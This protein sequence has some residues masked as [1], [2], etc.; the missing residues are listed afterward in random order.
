MPDVF[1][2]AARHRREVLERDTAAIK[3]LVLAYGQVY[4]RI[5]I[6]LDSLLVQMVAAKESG[7]E[8]SAAWLFQE[9]RLLLLERLVEQQI[10]DF[11]RISGAAIED[12]QRYLAILGEQHTRELIMLGLSP[13]PAG[14]TVAFSYLPREALDSL[15]GFLS[16]GSPLSDLLSELGTDASKSV[17]TALIQ[18]VGTGMGPRETAREIRTALGGNLTRALTISRQETLRAYREAS[19]QSAQRNSDVMRGWI[20]QSALGRRVCPLCIAKH[21][22]FHK[23]DERLNSHIACRCTQVWITKS[24]AELGFPGVEDTSVQR[25]DITPGADWFDGLKPSTQR[26]ILGNAKYAAWQSGAITLDDLVAEMHSRQWG[27]G[28]RER[29]LTEIVGQEEALRWRREARTG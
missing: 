19:Y 28:L 2:I 26:A 10:N 22:S 4:Q 16:D 7:Q 6:Q 29:S 13:L 1:D 14:A 12:E 8:I 21:G 23:P 3:R 20:W 27:D 18:A 9:Q 25:G 5:Q 15:V 17:R 24:W 11:A